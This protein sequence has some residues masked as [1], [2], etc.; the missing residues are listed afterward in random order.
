MYKRE[1]QNKVLSVKVHCHDN[2]SLWLMGEGHRGIYVLFWGTQRTVKELIMLSFGDVWNNENKVIHLS[3][4]TS[5]LYQD[6]AIDHRLWLTAEFHAVM[7]GKHCLFTVPWI[8]LLSHHHT[9]KLKGEITIIHF[10][11]W[12]INLILAMN[13]IHKISPSLFFLF[14]LCQKWWDR[15]SWCLFINYIFQIIPLWVLN[16]NCLPPFSSSHTARRQLLVPQ[17]KIIIRNVNKCTSGCCG[18]TTFF[19][20]GCLL[21]VQYL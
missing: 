14:S 2:C 10:T 19:G 16:I 5:A 11:S 4:R 21:T 13:W 1:N 20:Y 18:K 3:R 9:L 8:L 7:C 6:W 17:S 12:A 15:H